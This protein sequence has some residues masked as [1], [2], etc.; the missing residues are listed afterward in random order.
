MKMLTTEGR[1]IPLYTISSTVKA[2]FTYHP[3]FTIIE[4]TCLETFIY[5]MPIKVKCRAIATEGGGGQGGYS[6]I[7]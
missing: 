4:V 2:I 6:D 3:L 1:R 7:F 5:G